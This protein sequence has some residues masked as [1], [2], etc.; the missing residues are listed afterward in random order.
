MQKFRR[1][2]LSTA[3]IAIAFTAAAAPTKGTLAGEERDF[4]AK[5]VEDGMVEVRLGR[6][7]EHRATNAQVKQFGSRMAA[8]H[9]KA[10]VELAAIANAKGVPLPTAIDPRK[11]QEEMTL[12]GKV[13]SSFDREYMERMVKDHRQDLQEFEKQ[14]ATAKDPDVKAFAAK[15]VPT[16]RE[17]LKLAEAA[18]GAA[19]K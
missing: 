8:D 2:S 10:N 11:Q 19:K 4:V 1:I 17:H 18:L 7:A 9:G 16:L 15:T 5:A 6:L 12:G 13:G 3:L 14:A